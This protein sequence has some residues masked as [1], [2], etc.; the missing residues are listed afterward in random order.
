MYTV[1]V[2]LADINIRI[3]TNYESISK[4]MHEYV[5]DD[6]DDIAFCVETSDEERNQCK[7]SLINSNEGCSFSADYVEYITIHSLIAEALLNYDILLMHGSCLTIDDKTIIFT[8]TSGTGKSTHSGLYREVYGDRVKMINDDKPFLICKE[9]EIIVCGNP[10]QGKH[11]LGTNTKAKLDAIVYL[12]RGPENKIIP[13]EAQDVFEL[14]F[15]QTYYSK[16]K[17]NK[18]KAF[19]LL[20]NICKNVKMFKLKCNMDKDAAI[21][22]YSGIRDGLL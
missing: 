22:S 13:V 8:A 4:R 7:E 3:N 11:N 18:I 15:L 20:S 14:L 10:W 21:V 5:I 6:T 19:Q 2:Q 12:E 9:N 16:N 1:V 17:L